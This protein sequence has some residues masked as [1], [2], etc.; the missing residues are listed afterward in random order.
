MANWTSAQTKA[1]ETRDKT[2][3]ISAA[4]GSGKTAVLIERI[5]RLLTDPVEPIDISRLLI[6]TFT[7]AAASE[8][9]QR[10]SKALS[11]AI[12]G[13]PS[14]KRLFSQLASLGSAHISTI[15]SFYADVVKK[16][17]AKLGIPPSLRIADDSELS[18]LRRRIMDDVM[19]M[20]YRGEF[21][22]INGIENVSF[23]NYEGATPFTAFADSISD[24]RNDSGTWEILADLRSKLLSHPRSTDFLIDCEL[25]YANAARSDLFDTV[26][27]TVLRRHLTDKVTV[28]VS[29]L[30][31]A[32]DYLTLDGNMA[33]QYLPAFSYDLDFCRELL[34]TLDSGTY[35]STREKVLSYAPLKLGRL[36]AAQKTELCTDYAEFRKKFVKEELE[37]FK[38]KYFGGGCS[39]SELVDHA[40]RSAVTCK[41][42]HAILSKFEELYSEEKLSRGICEFSDIKLWAYRL[43]VSPEGTP[44]DIALEIADTFDAVYIDEYQDVDPVQDLI[45]RCISKPRGRFMV[46]DVKQSI[47][48]FRG[49]DPSL[50]MNYRSS[51]APIDVDS[52]KLPDEDDCTIFMSSNFRCD[53]NVIK[54][55]NSVCSYLFTNAKGGIKYAPEDDLEFAKCR[56]DGYAPSEAPAPVS[57]VLVDKHTK[58]KDDSSVDESEDEFSNL[59][60][61][62]IASEIKRLISSE[63]KN[64]GTDISPGDIAVFARAEKF[65]GLVAA[66]LDRLGIEHS[67]GKGQSIF[68]DPEVMIALSLLH[69]IDNPRRDVH[70]AGALMSPIFGFSADELIAIRQNDK[71]CALYDAII[72]YSEEND[73]MTAQKCKSTLGVIEELRT[74]SASM[75]AD[76][77]VRTIFSRFSLLSRKEGDGDSRRALLALYENARKYEGDEFK[78]LY[79]YLIYVEDMIENKK[80]PSVSSDSDNAVQLMTIHKSK[81]LEFPVCFVAS[82]GSKFNRDDTKNTLLYSPELGIS[83]D[84]LDADGFGKIKTSYRNALAIQI[85]NM[86]TEEEMRL[87][88]VALTR[89]RERLY[90]TASSSKNLENRVAFYSLYPSRGTVMD[91]NNYISWILASLKRLG[92]REFFRIIKVSS[93]DISDVES[94][95]ESADDEGNESAAEYSDETLEAVRKN[96]EF[97]YPYLHVSSLPAKLSVSKLSPG[98]LDRSTDS[99]EDDDKAE[100]LDIVLPDIYGTPSFMSGSNELNDLTAA[101]KGTATHTFL[102]FCDF[103][104]AKKIGVKAELERLV[105]DGFIDIRRRDAV[106]TRQLE[107]FFRS[108][109]F[110]DISNAR[111]VWREQRFNILLPAA[112]FTEN[113]EYGKLINDEKLLVQGVMDLFFEDQNGDLILCD[114]KTDFL[115]YD[116]INDPRLAREKLCRAHSRQLSYYAEALHSMFGKYPDKVLIYSLPLGDTVEVDTFAILDAEN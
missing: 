87:L 26:H 111:R 23:P 60:A 53:E 116:E 101:E 32:C 110:E 79:S 81:G 15:D 57:V 115:T 100:S 12:A 103:D 70:L 95:L 33:K 71:K 38:K 10:I 92:E 88:Y 51:F 64:N 43:I 66:E 91:A 50:F 108:S 83:T 76:K 107:S 80:A 36:S 13:D 104:N 77:I 78:G 54:F 47:Y 16:Y 2:L 5:I 29:F 90:V 45:F 25:E 97:E 6:V 55:A 42:L 49:S 98:V 61:A 102:Q 68:D 89:A 30:T 28:M 8:L 106:N 99:V 114:Y 46:G 84:I 20:G 59:E 94:D 85:T 109:L 86:G 4:A 3:L 62:Y 9:R 58:N 31:D 35:V 75:P 39:E 56:I 7:R 17:S 73:D 44:T 27:G 22:K 14:N 24:M 11:A 67:G 37:S 41:V 105:R 74:A 65:L 19:D 96:F 52:E 82:S 93:D 112:A 63:K 1:I 113:D 18:P 40:A 21:D 34:A 69:T 48:G 72:K